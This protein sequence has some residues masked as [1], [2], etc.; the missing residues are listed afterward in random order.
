MTKIKENIGFVAALLSIASIVISVYSYFTV[1]KYR[2]MFEAIQPLEMDIAIDKPQDGAQVS[3][4]VTE[5]TGQIRIKLGYQST[6]TD[7][8]LEIAKRNID[9]FP[10]V[11]PMSEANTWFAQTKPLIGSDGSFQSSV[12]IGDKEGRGIGMNFQI[13]V[14]AVP[15]GTIHQGDTFR[16]LPPYG[17][18]SK[19]ITVRRI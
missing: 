3:H 15:K 5:I 19:V 4:C 18:S 8:N 2:K 11:R 17:A 10:L 7:V 16:D 14:I 9:I 13:A 6:R 1:D 12:N